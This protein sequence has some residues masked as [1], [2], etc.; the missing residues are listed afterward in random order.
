MFAAQPNWSPRWGNPQP[1]LDFLRVI[2][3]LS[4]IILGVGC[5]AQG[6]KLWCLTHRGKDE[7]EKSV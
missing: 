7:D 5:F 3:E 1:F 2:S 6:G 4:H